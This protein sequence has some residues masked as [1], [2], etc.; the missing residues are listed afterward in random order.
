MPTH[1]S[2][3]PPSAPLPARLCPMRSLLPPALFAALKGIFWAVASAYVLLALML[4]MSSSVRD[5]AR[6]LGQF[7]TTLGVPLEQRAYV[8]ASDPQSC[9]FSV[10]AVVSVL[11]LYVPIHFAM[12]FFVTAASG[13]WVLGVG[14]SVEMEL[15]E[16][17]LRDQL[18]NFRECWW[19]TF[20]VDLVGADGLGVV[21]GL[22]FF[23]WWYLGSQRLS[24]TSSPQRQ[25]HLATSYSEQALCALRSILVALICGCMLLSPFLVKHALWIPPHHPVYLVL[26]FVV[27]GLVLAWLVGGNT[28]VL[29][30]FSTLQAL[31]CVRLLFVPDSHGDRPDGTR[32]YVELTQHSVT[33]GMFLKGAAC[34]G[35]VL[36]V[37]STMGGWPKVSFLLLPLA[38]RSANTD[39]VKQA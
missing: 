33:L 13:S 39:F 32:L 38:Q 28:P 9:T 25:R 8:D 31:L 20:V 24:G 36:A 17:L 35:S 22:L 10:A 23:R 4:V 12:A 7:D 1:G 14:L 26:H 37:C 11:D 27:D 34:A 18:A 19:D 15:I 2:S 30:W 29:L 21:G 3:L 16:W 6:A 5:V